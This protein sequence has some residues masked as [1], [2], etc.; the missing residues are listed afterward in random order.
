MEHLVPE[1]YPVY[2]KL[3]EDVKSVY[4]RPYPLPKL[5]EEILKVVERL[6]TCSSP[7][8]PLCCHSLVCSENNLFIVGIGPIHD[9]DI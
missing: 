5:H 8:C 3:K 2:L 4:S 1:K 7:R 6:V 9:E